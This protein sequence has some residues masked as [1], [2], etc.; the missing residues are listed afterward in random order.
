MSSCA[1][2]SDTRGDGADVLPAREE[3][4]AGHG[5]LKLKIMDTSRVVPRL[6]D[7]RGDGARQLEGATRHLSPFAAAYAV[8]PCHATLV[9]AAAASGVVLRVA[10]GILR[11]GLLVVAGE[12]LGGR[13]RRGTDRLI[14]VAAG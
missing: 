7:N 4:N 8:R 1:I 6:L 5:T 12:D 11:I 3:A 2:S 9:A 10:D 14:R 13:R